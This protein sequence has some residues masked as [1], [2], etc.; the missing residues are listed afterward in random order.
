MPDEVIQ[1]FITL[2]LKSIFYSDVELLNN[3]IAT[4]YGLAMTWLLITFGIRGCSYLTLALLLRS[5][6]CLIPINQAILRYAQNDRMNGENIRNL[7]FR[8][9][10]GIYQFDYD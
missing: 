6:F 4:P 10:F 2:I 7:S 3:W 5:G 9:Y 1:L 8:I